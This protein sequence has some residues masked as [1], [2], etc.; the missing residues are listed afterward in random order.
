LLLTFDAQNM[1]TV[2]SA[3]EGFT[4]SGSGSF[5]E[6]GDK[7]SWGDQDRNVIYLD[8]TIDMG[9]RSYATKDTLVVRDRGVTMETFSP[10]FKV[11]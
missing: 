1:C 6:D 9:A 2:S 5:V 10:S 11:N 7:N 8:Y 4:V 3:S